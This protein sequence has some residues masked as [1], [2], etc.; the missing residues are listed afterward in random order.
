MRTPSTC[1]A[2]SIEKSGAATAAQRASRTASVD[3]RPMRRSITECRLPAIGSRA[4]SERSP[5]AL[6]PPS[7]AP[8]SPRTSQAFSVSSRYSGLP[9]QWRSSVA[10]VVPPRSEAMPSESTIS[11]TW[12]SV[13]RL[14]RHRDRLAMRE[15]LVEEQASRR[16]HLGVA[17]GEDPAPRRR[18]H[19]VLQQLDAAGVR[20]VQVVEGDALDRQR[21]GVERRAHRIE[22]ARPAFAR[23]AAT[24]PA[25]RARAAA[26]RALP[27]RARRA[28][29][30]RRRAARAAGAT[31]RRRRR[32]R[33]RDARRRRG[34]GRG[35]ARSRR[36]AG[37]CPCRLRR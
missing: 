6:A 15:R 25:R 4:G 12:A 19:R 17:R 9:P 20:E 23:V 21:L 5:A 1:E 8:A 34:F 7:P 33:R 18:A 13:E 3:R 36:S 32:A 29:A 16:R 2:S 35:R 37:S 28:S 30:G 24:T 31:A 27:A 14:E 22:E 10:A 11:E 26:T